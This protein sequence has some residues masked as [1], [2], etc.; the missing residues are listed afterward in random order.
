MKRKY[1]FLALFAATYLAIILY[2]FAYLLSP[3]LSIQQHQLI[4]G[5]ILVLIAPV[6]YTGFKHFGF[7]LITL[8]LKYAVLK[9]SIIQ[10][11]FAGLIV[12]I[13]LAIANGLLVSYTTDLSVVLFSY[14]NPLIETGVLLA[15]LFGL[16]IQVAVVQYLKETLPSQSQIESAFEEADAFVQNENN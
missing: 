3:L 8:T 7:G 5:G 1:K 9:G 6:Y 13:F 15:C 2:P 14:W 16:L 4:L 11:A 12:F 10:R